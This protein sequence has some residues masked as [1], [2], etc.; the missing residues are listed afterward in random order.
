[1]TIN[2]MEFLYMVVFCFFLNTDIIL[3]SNI[4]FQEWDT[5]ESTGA[6]AE[7]SVRISIS[8]CGSGQHSS[9]SSSC[10]LSVTPSADSM[11]AKLGQFDVTDLVMFAAQIAS[12]MVSWEVITKH[13]A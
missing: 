4:V 3:I 8:G 7:S 5:F 6:S 13:K 12:G 9:T 1:M 10:L 11:Y 2:R